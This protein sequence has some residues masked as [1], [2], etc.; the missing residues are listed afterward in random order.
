MPR[1]Y[2]NCPGISSPRAGRSSE[3]YRGLIGT[4]E[5]VE[6]S[7]PSLRRVELASNSSFQTCLASLART[8]ISNPLCDLAQDPLRNFVRWAVAVELFR[9][10]PAVGQ[11][12]PGPV[13]GHVSNHL[14]R[15]VAQAL[16]G[17]RR[18]PPASLQARA[19]R[20]DRSPDHIES[21]MLRG[22]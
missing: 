3:V 8:F 10:L 12:L 14:H 6:V 16:L 15:L 9:Q 4:P 13:A 19:V 17:Q 20:L 18:R 2:G 1:V 5:M 11:R 21:I 22:V 7:M